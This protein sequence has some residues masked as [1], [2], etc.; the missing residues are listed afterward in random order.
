MKVT[1]QLELDYNLAKQDD[2]KFMTRDTIKEKVAADPEVLII[3]PVP[4]AG[5]FAIK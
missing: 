5:Q 3:V 1:E 2:G 4:F